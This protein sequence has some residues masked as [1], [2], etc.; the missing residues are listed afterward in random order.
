MYGTSQNRND[1]YTAEYIITLAVEK[2]TSLLTTAARGVNLACVTVDLPVVGTQPFFVVHYYVEGSNESTGLPSYHDFVYSA[3]TLENATGTPAR[4]F[5][6]GYNFYFTASDSFL[7]PDLYT[8]NLA[9]TVTST[10]TST[11][12]TTTTPPT[13]TSTRT[14]STSTRTYC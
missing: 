3:E 4:F 5:P 11:P 9:T 12:T 7:F 10:P 6:T 8:S 2:G 1:T 13:T 14:T